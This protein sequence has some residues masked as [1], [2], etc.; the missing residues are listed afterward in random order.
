MQQIKDYII[1]KY[2]IDQDTEIQQTT[3]IGNDDYFFIICFFNFCDKLVEDLEKISLIYANGYFGNPKMFV[4]QNNDETID[5]VRKI[6]SKYGYRNDP[7]G[8]RNYVICKY[9]KNKYKN[10]DKLKFD[11]ERCKFTYFDSE[12]IDIDN[13]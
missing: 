6:I 5:R 11:W 7:R 12:K 2:L 13:L 4:L 1:E 3:S 9:P 8:K 10:F